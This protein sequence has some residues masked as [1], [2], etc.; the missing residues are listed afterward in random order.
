MVLKNASYK[1]RSVG[2]YS[3]CLCLCSPP[4]DM[5][6]A[7][8][9]IRT[10]SHSDNKVTKERDLS[11]LKSRTDRAADPAWLIY[12]GPDGRCVVGRATLTTR[13]KHFVHLSDNLH[14]GYAVHA[15]LRLD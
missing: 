14:R 8:S 15:P 7:A 12:V 11:S 13:R 6:R 3:S 4:G 10:Y 5:G 9:F 2:D 1:E